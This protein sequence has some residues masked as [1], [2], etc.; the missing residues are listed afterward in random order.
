MTK[1]C[2]FAAVLTMAIAVV[3]AEP[4]AAQVTTGTIVGTV[5]DANGI[6]PARHRY[7]PR[8]EPRHVGHVRDRR[9]RAATRRRS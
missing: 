3:A 9:D 7:H 4:S 8:S 2:I 1:R 6:V 5:S